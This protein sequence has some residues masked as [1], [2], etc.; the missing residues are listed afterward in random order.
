[1]KKTI[2]NYK[3]WYD[4]NVYLETCAIL[5]PK[6]CYDL[7]VKAIQKDFSS[8][9]LKK[10]MAKQKEVFCARSEAL[11]NNFK[12]EFTECYKK[13]KAKDLYLKHEL[14]DN[15]KILYFNPIKDL[16]FENRT[17]ILT[18]NDLINIREYI[19]K[20]LIIGKESFL[21]VHSPNFKFQYEK[22]TN[23]YV[24]ARATF[25]YYNWLIEFS[26]SQVKV[27]S[28]SNVNNTEKEVK[29]RDVRFTLNLIA[30]IYFYD[31]H[32]ITRINGKEIAAK[33][34]FTSGEKLY[35]FYCIVSSKIYRTKIGGESKT[36]CNN[37]LKYIERAMNHL[38]GKSKEKAKMDYLALELAIEKHDW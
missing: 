21:F 37:R 23:D 30:L 3:D 1:M 26:K 36:K 31:G 8:T 19:N 11:F 14:E 29:K 22:I 6:N 24:Y 17:F 13:S 4:G 38:K 7:P 18:K 34:G 33:Y 35:N 9:D 27:A 16:N 2:Y 12:K 25:D 15:K 28:I 5:I 10:I 20:Q 32:Q